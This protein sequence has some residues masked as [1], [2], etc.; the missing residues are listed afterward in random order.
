MNK[1]L[2]SILSVLLVISFFV[3]GIFGY[4][5][6]PK[7]NYNNFL[8]NK[9][10]ERLFRE[11]VK[12]IKLQKQ[13]I[14]FVKN[15]KFKESFNLN[16]YKD[17]FVLNG[18]FCDIND[19]FFIG[20]EE[21][22]KSQNIIYKPKIEI[23]EKLE[24]LLYKNIGKR[25]KKDN[26]KYQICNFINSENKTDYIEI[27]LENYEYSKQELDDLKNYKLVGNYTINK[28]YKTPIESVLNSQ[29]LIEKISYEFIYPNENISI[30][31]NLLK[32]GGKDLFNSNI[33]KDGEI[34]KGIGGGS[35]LA[36]TIIY[37]TL[38][39]AGIEIKSQKTHNIYYENI[40]GIGEIGLDSTIYEDE[41]YFVDLI[42]KNN[43]KNPII[44]I[45]NFDD[46]KI[47]LNI[48][49]K[50]KEY[51]TKLTPLDI[52]NVGNIKW[53][54]EIFDKNNNKIGEYTLG[55]KYD[56]IDNF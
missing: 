40:Y 1:L 39:N 38:L 49:S 24:L 42:F 23:N 19:S 53:N 29:N 32:D 2:I 17:Y 25:I 55:S 4:F 6:I 36:S 35:C 11:D 5:F 16:L 26:L 41:T 20:I 51:T 7:I 37:R 28:Y 44:F 43:Y 52:E 31:E 56:K 33:L 10:K 9:Q 47:T 45:P 50:E 46:N 27:E 22:L 18:N 13:L 30:L 21:K 54:Y 8:A 48:Y 3:I 15:Y 34:I 12:N 14:L